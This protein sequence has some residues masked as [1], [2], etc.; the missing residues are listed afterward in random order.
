MFQVDGK[1]N[2]RFS[3]SLV[4]CAARMN[5]TD[6]ITLFFSSK[7]RHQ[8]QGISNYSEY[9]TIWH[10]IPGIHQITLKPNPKLEENATFF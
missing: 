3:M 7:Y 9:A 5:A 6:N 4:V 1:E 2:V 10:V 8:A